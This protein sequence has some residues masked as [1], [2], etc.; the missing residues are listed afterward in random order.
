MV[1][2]HSEVE[3]C[4]QELQAARSRVVLEE[5]VQPE[6]SS[7]VQTLPVYYGRYIS[8]ECSQ[9][10]CTICFDE[11]CR[12]GLQATYAGLIFCGVLQV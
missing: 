1:A 4:S 2:A 5:Q 11:Q 9:E 3:N 7:F 10:G 8:L 6:H 12:E